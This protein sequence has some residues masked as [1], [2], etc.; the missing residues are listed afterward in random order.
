MNASDPF[1]HPALFYRGEEEYLAGT[2]P[3]IQGGLATGQ[4]V[5]VAVPTERLTLVR[6]ELGATADRVLLIDMAVA[7]RN[8]GRIIPG[9]LCAFADAHPAERVRIIG[10]PLWPS[11]S[12]AEYPACVQHE[13]LVNMAFA[14]RKATILCPYDAG[15]LSPDA[16][17]DAAA[18][19]P[20]VIE[21]GN[22][23]TSPTYAPEQMIDQYNRPLPR[24]C[25]DAQATMNFDSTNLRQAGS[26]SHEYAARL[27]LAATRL[28][29]LEL[30][31]SELVVNFAARGGGTG[32]LRVW[33]DA[34][35]LVCEVCEVC[36]SG[37]FTDPLVGRLP[38]GVRTTAGRAMLVANYVA[39]LVRVYATAD[40]TAV[41]L[42]FALSA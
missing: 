27:G 5:A 24:P 34:G 38:G 35:D 22:E 17:A 16:L 41:Q 4:P 32:T 28:P 37:D 23:Q 9:L 29:D 3:Y 26:F 21:E 8:P 25:D 12:P 19:H 14:H 1:V 2:V 31:V 40:E 39:D 20:T 10:E 30:A 13:A 18:T 11:R 7:G 6:T 33:A 42:H 15:A 36:D